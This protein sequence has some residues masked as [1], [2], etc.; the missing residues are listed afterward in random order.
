MTEPETDTTAEAPTPD[1]GPEKDAIEQ[2]DVLD[3]AHGFG[4]PSAGDDPLAMSDPT[5]YGG[6]PLPMWEPEPA[7]KPAPRRSAMSVSKT[8]EDLYAR[9]PEVGSG[10]KSLRVSRRAPKIYNGQKIAGFLGDLHEQMS[11]TDFA[12]RFGGGSYQVLVRGPGRSLDSDGSYSTIT[13]DEIDVEVTGKPLAVSVEDQQMSTQ[14]GAP[15][16]PYVNPQVE[17]TRMQLDRQSQREAADRNERWMREAVGSQQVPQDLFAHIEAVSQKRATEVRTTLQGTVEDLRRDNEQ[18]TKR[19]QAKDDEMHGTRQRMMEVQN[20]AAHRLREEESTRV[21]ELKEQHSAR[22]QQIKEEQATS[23]E[24]LAKDHTSRLSELSER[25]TRERTLYEQSSQVE[26]DRLR[27]DTRRREEQITNDSRLREQTT[28]DNYESRISETERSHQ[29][30]ISSIKENRDRELSSIQMSSQG[31]LTISEKASQLQIQALNNELSMLRVKTESQER[32]LYELRA[33]AHKSPIEAIGEARELL[34]SVGGGKTEDEGEFDWKKAAFLAVKGITEKFPE[35]ME[36]MAAARANN[37]Q[38]REMAQ[39]QARAR[40]MAIRQRQIQQQQQH[41]LPAAQQQAM[42][43]QGAPAAP[44]E[45]SDLPGQSAPT[46]GSPLGMPPEPGDAAMPPAPTG[47]MAPAATPPPAP[48]PSGS[49]GP[50]QSV[51]APPSTGEGPQSAG[52]VPGF[53]A[54]P[55]PE[56]TPEPAKPV[57][58]AEAVGQAPAQDQSAMPEITEEAVKEFAEKLEMAISSEM[59]TPQEFA[60]GFIEEVGP[61][62]AGKITTSIHPDQFADSIAQHPDG[63]ST[64]IVTREG[65]KYLHELWEAIQNLL[66]EPSPS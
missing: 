32:E 56:P 19:I 45:R 14:R 4:A 34:D 20:E 30:E 55:E 49:E 28:R 35:G 25:H 27:E 50:R 47:P 15:E 66:T 18:L 51:D 42:P 52:L 63:A 53:M 62:V 64:Q 26:R 1:P 36:R 9:H 17:I 33:T 11:L 60:K 8:L 29:R 40:A 54:V 59:I 31:N 65:R 43:M 57:E 7:P 48:V 6:A 2:L 16:A 13:L 44:A 10:T 21:K 3:Q 12:A 37:Q 38:G 39:A 23:I 58:A 46:W 41:Q 5:S 22:I 61:A 24:R